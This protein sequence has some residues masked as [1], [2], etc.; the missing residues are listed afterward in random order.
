MIKLGKD[1]LVEA[2]AE[3]AGSKAKAR[4]VLDAV[5]DAAADALARGDAV[6]LTGLGTLT[7][8]LRQGRSGTTPAGEDWTTG[9]AM[10]VRFG[11]AKGLRDRLNPA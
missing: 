7:P 11:L 10:G 8:V 1:Y 6:K 4:E 9:A 2:A 3:A 5:L